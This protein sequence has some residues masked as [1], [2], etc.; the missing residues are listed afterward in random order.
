MSHKQNVDNVLWYLQKDPHCSQPLDKVLISF[1]QLLEDFVMVLVQ[2]A[3][4]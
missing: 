1:L 4:S 3:L 2:W